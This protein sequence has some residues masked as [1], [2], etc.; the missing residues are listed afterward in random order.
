[1]CPIRPKV[2]KLGGELLPQA[3]LDGDGV[4]DDNDSEKDGDGI[5]DA[6]DNCVWGS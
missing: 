3:D 1:M 2:I 5:E 6:Q 4:G